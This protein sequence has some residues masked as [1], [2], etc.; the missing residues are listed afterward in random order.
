M[1]GVDWICVWRLRRGRLIG[2]VAVYRAVGWLRSTL[3]P[4]LSHFGYV[5]PSTPLHRR[6][7]QGAW[8]Y[9]DQGFISKSC[10]TTLEYGQANLD[11]T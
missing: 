5:T 7:I 10:V 3:L 2:E 11:R 9:W 8:H 4:S 6:M 1:I